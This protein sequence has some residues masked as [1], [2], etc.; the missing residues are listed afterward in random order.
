MKKFIVVTVLAFF[1][2][3]FVMPKG[4]AQTYAS[5]K[6]SIEKVCKAADARL[7]ATSDN[8][9]IDHEESSRCDGI[10][11]ARRGCCSHHGGVCGCTSGRAQCCD[12]ALS[13]SCG[14]D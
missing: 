3:T 4:L 2:F 12:G 8:P 5:T 13:P 9:L 10:E 11:V 6:V 1:V 7:D 14:C